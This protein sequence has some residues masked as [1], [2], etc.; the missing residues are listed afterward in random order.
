MTSNPACRDWERGRLACNVAEASSFG[1]N[2]KKH[3]PY[4]RVGCY[5]V[6]FME[7][8]KKFLFFLQRFPYNRVY[9]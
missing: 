7:K 9:Q 4:G 8:S 3:S 6:L 5:L 2:P 1:I